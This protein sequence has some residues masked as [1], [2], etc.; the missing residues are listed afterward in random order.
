MRFCFAQW[1]SF[2]HSL[3]GTWIWT[4]GKKIKQFFYWF[5]NSYYYK[6]ISFR[7]ISFC[8]GI[9]SARPELILYVIT[10][11]PFDWQGW[12]FLASFFLCFFSSLHFPPHVTAFF[13]LLS[14]P[15][16]F[17]V[18]VLTIVCIFSPSLFIFCP[19]FW[20]LSVVLWFCSLC[21]TLYPS[22]VYSSVPPCL[23]LVALF[24]PS[25]SFI[26]S[27]FASRF[28]TYAVFNTVLCLPLQ[29]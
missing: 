27:S 5:V 15:S 6:G 25:D 23:S 8:S 26:S 18:Y 11:H 24:T 14:L 9:S 2:R 13:L 19:L 12:L 29:P 22:P 21:S 10:S 1:L 16:P 28:L 3:Q 20:S 17:W 4:N 7:E